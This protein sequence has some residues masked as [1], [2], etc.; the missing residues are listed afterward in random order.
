M[1]GKQFIK[2]AGQSLPLTLRRN[3]QAKHITMRLSSDGQSVK[4]TLPKRCAAKQAIAFAHTQTG[5]LEKQLLQAPQLIS[6]VPNEPIEVLGDTLVFSHANSRNSH[7]EGHIFYMGGE[8]EFFARRVEASIKKMARTCFS[9]IAQELAQ[10]IDVEIAGIALRDTRSRW[11]S[12]SSQRK[13]NLSWRLA[14]AP[15][16]VAR[17]VIAH[18]VAHLVHFNHSAEFW[19]LVEQLHPYWQKDRAWLK[20]KGN[21]LHQIVIQP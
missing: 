18:E 11:G 8:P 17:Y 13:I 20:K 1:S 12:C 5:W 16:N 2:V 14:F 4:I 7:Q 6:L 10:Q 21:Q 19:Q 15:L 9:D 3:A